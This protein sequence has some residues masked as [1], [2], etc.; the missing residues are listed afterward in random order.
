MIDHNGDIQ[1]PDSFIPEAEQLGLIDEI[2]RLVMAKAIQSLGSFLSDGF[3]LSLSVNLSGKAMDNPDIL[4]LIQE[5]LKQF[6]V[7]PSRLV[8]EI[9]ETVAV[10]DIAGAERLMRKIKELGCHF[11]LDDFGVGFSS[12]FYLKQLPVDIVKLDGMFVRQLPHSKE[13]QIFVKALNDMAHGLGKQTVAEF[14]ENEQIL[15]MLIQY[16][17][18]YAQG[19]HIGKP[20]PDILRV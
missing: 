5:Q 1:T 3:D 19:Y 18:D 11:A 2:D 8:I 20:L 15:Q 17:V 13:D 14:V 9:T 4:L 10:A 7:E 12:F 6:N 16:G